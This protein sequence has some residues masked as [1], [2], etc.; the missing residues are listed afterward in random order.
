MSSQKETRH[1]AGQCQPKEIIILCF[2]NSIFTNFIILNF[3]MMF[4]TKHY[5]NLFNGL[6][7]PTWSVSKQ[8]ALSGENVFFPKCQILLQSTDKNTK[9]SL[10]QRQINTTKIFKLLHSDT[11]SHKQQGQPHFYQE[12]EKFSITHKNS[13]ITEKELFC[14]NLR[15]KYLCDESLH[16]LNPESHT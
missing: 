5:E 7:Y 10:P 3:F 12:H 6:I 15:S 14:Y 11:K 8:N 9:R 13:S 16:R 2:Q 1:I 4:N